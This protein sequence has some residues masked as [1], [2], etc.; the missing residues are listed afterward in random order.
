MPSSLPAEQD[1][2]VGTTV[3]RRLTIFSLV[4]RFH[5]FSSV[6][7]QISSGAKPRLT[8]GTIREIVM[9]N[10][11]AERYRAGSS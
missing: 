1:I 10:G 5:G 6:I 2:R 11:E 4:G 8:K 7:T 9:S 3:H